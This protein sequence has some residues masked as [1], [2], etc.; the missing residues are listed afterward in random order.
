MS[1]PIRLDTIIPIVIAPF[2][3]SL[4]IHVIMR[5][6]NIPQKNEGY[7]FSILCIA[8]ACWAMGPL[9]NIYYKNYGWYSALF[10]SNAAI[11]YTLYITNFKLLKIFL[12]LTILSSGS[13][14]F[15][16][17]SGQ[18]SLPGFQIKF[19]YLLFPLLLF[20]NGVIYFYYFKY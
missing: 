3:I 15:L 18:S 17:I 10:V 6:K 19:S 4:C 5:L 14:L 8:T 1:L 9:L 16:L 11:L 7:I 13:I 20:M 2:C 12:P